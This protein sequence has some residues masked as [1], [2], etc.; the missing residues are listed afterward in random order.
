M[1][2]DPAKGRLW[3]ICP[4]CTRWNLV[5]IEERWE[6]VEACE[7]H[8]RRAPRQIAT[9]NIGLVALPEGLDLI[10][11]GAPAR[12]EFAAWRY[13]R[14]F[15]RRHRRLVV[16][17]G[18]SVAGGTALLLPTLAPQLLVILPAV[19]LTVTQSRRYKD[20]L[21][22][23]LP[24]SDGVVLT[25]QRKHVGSAHI[26]TGSRNGGWMLHVTHAQGEQHF[27]GEEAIRPLGH[28]LAFVNG[29][30]G[31]RGEV[32]DAV[33]AI[34]EVGNPVAYLETIATRHEGSTKLEDIS[35][36]DRLAL[37]MATQEE[38]ERR[39][40]EDDLAGLEQEWRE[41]EEIAAIADNLLLP[42]SVTSW[43]RSHRK[44]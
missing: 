44:G 7:R 39:A 2:F 23:R 17:A 12:P 41:A 35:P 40:M 36:V 24:A 16:A 42:A 18:L 8:F 11:I 29:T 37:E 5:P 14:V 13:G 43:V 15:A 4:R 3:V 32:L 33:R 30:G 38:V 6:A 34:E 9:D 22:A 31:N 19:Y 1:A 26:E 28:L 10:R 27:F 25:V 21:V 20:R